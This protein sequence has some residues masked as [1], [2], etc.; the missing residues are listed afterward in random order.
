MNSAPMQRWRKRYFL[1]RSNKKMEYYED[2]TLQDMK[3]VINLESC[4]NLQSAVSYRKHK[5]VIRIDT[6]MRIYFMVS[7]SQKDMKEWVEVLSSLCGDEVTQGIVLKICTI[8]ITY[9][10]LV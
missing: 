2:D 4:I 1:V 6:M 7:D 9:H 3:G 5:N 8:F 10:S